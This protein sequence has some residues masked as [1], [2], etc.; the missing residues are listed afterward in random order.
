LR[1]AS[2]INVTILRDG[3]SERLSIP[4]GNPG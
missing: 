4:L 2:M 3:R 1:D